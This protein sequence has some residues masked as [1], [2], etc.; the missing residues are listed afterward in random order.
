MD[1][2][3]G[4]FI[5]V[6]EGG[7]AKLAGGTLSDFV[8]SRDKNTSPKFVAPVAVVG[9]TF[10]IKSGSI[11]NNIVGYIVEDSKAY[12]NANNIKMYVKGAAPN[13]QRKS[14]SLRRNSMAGIDNGQAGS[15]ITATA[16]AVIYVG[17]AQGTVSGGTISMNRGDTGGIMAS[18]A[19]TKVTL[20]N[21]ININNNV[22]VQFGGGTTT[23][24]G[25]WLLMTGGTIKENVAWFG[26]G[27]VYATE[28][29]VKWLLGEQNDKDARKDGWFTMDGGTIDGNTSSLVAAQ[30][31]QTLTVSP[32]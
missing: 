1:A 7:K 20:E 31:L 13:A 28:N 10:D 27:A 25:A 9:G 3:K 18:G 23:E 14:G 11:T 4:F 30:S 26:G 2:P 15:G 12:E 6:G 8:T 17:G 29:G 24:D 22:G 19:N 32:L 5:Q 21:E 16:G